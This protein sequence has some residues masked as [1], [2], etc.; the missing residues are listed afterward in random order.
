M[1]PRSIRELVR[2][3]EKGQLEEERDAALFM[4]RRGTKEKWVMEN[5]YMGVVTQWSDEQGNGFLEEDKTGDEL[6]VNRRSV[7]R[8][9]EPRWR[10]NLCIGELVEFAKCPCPKGY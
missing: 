10:H 4:D 6:F 3:S 2:S 9:A 7:K 5:R 1:W 8:V